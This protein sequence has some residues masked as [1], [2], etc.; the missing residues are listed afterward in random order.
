[1]N[2]DDRQKE[3]IKRKNEINKIVQLF[4]KKLLFF[5]TINF[6]SAFLIIKCVIAQYEITYRLFI[7]LI[8]STI[9]HTHTPEM[10]SHLI[11]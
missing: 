2:A 6:L 11:A 5:S 9:T 7:I 8:L 3:N 4:I 10:K 1:M